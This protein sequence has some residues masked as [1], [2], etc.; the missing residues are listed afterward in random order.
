MEIFEE[1]RAEKMS[2]REQKAKEKR[3]K[4]GGFKPVTPKAPPAEDV[5]L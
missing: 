4:E 2:G 3:Q 1:K 5:E